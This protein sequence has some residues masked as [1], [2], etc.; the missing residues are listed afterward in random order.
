MR[1]THQLVLR[2]IAACIQHLGAGMS[3]FDVMS[4]MDMQVRQTGRC[5]YGYEFLYLQLLKLYK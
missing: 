3:R 5:G 1:H 4:E 2:G